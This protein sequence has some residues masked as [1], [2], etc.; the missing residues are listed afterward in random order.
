MKI[1]YFIQLKK[2]NEIY[3]KKVL[4]A[5][6]KGEDKD[7]ESMGQVNSSTTSVDRRVGT[8]NSLSGADQ[9]TY[10]EVKKKPT[11]NGTGRSSKPKHELFRK[12]RK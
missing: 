4:I 11:T 12:Y 2:N 1:I 10:I 6:D 8:M 5:T 9:T 3:F 7:E